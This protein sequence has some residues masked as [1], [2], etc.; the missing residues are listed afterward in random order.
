MAAMAY[1]LKKYMAYATHYSHKSQVAVALKKIAC[2]YA[3]LF[4]AESAFFITRIDFCNSHC[5]YG[6]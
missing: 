3:R 4:W 1:N 2:F 6:K 5:H